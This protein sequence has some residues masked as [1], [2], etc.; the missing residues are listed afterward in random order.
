MV[1]DNIT[2][3]GSGATTV[4]SDDSGNITINS[5]NTN[6]WKANTSSSEGYVA[7]GA[8]Q[9]IKF[10]KLMRM[11]YPLGVMMQAQMQ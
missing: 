5:T 4:V 9:K 1:R 8:N 7:S 2:I 10:G 6:T 11:A 3:K